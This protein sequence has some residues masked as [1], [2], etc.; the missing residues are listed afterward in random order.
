MKVFCVLLI[1]LIITMSQTSKQSDKMPLNLEFEL[2]LRIGI[3]P[4]TTPSNPHM[5]LDQQPTDR[6]LVNELMNWA[7]SLPT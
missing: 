2:P 5:Q 4:I 3:K 7:F 6:K 1:T